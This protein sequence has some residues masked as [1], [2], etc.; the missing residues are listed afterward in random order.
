ME[1]QWLGSESTHSVGRDALEPVI[2]EIEE[3]HLRL[4]GLE[5]E[6]SQLLHLQTGLE[7]QLEL[8]AFDHNVGE[9]QQMHLQGVGIT[10]LKK[11]LFWLVKQT[12][13]IPC[14][15]LGAS[16]PGGPTCLSWSQ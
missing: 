15:L 12:S 10:S 1:R 11:T 2:I 6:V 13:H 3:D 14:F 9:I 16:P 5:D 8:T 4:S 7:W